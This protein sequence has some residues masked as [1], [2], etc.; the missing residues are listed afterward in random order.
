MKHV[1]LKRCVLSTL[2]SL[3][4]L[5]DNFPPNAIVAPRFSLTKSLPERLGSEMS[6]L[7]SPQGFRKPVAAP[8]S[9]MLKKSDRR[10][11][12]LLLT[13]QAFKERRK[14]E[15][16]RKRQIKAEEARLAR[17]LGETVWFDE[18]ASKPRYF[19]NRASSNNNTLDKTMMPFLFICRKRTPLRRTS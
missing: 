17:L 16:K 4:P 1:K 11:E 2:T 9:I 13:K 3:Y 5:P 10:G 19:T 8:L 18:T 12:K 6:Q 15:K 14:E 7:S